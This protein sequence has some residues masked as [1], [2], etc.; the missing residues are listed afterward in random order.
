MAAKRLLDKEEIRRQTDL[1]EVVAAHVQLKASGR[2]LRGL[3]P[4]HP[5]KTGS[6]YVDPDKGLWHCFGCKAGGDVFRFVELISGL[7]FVEAAQWLAR[8][9]GGEYR[10]SQKVERS[11]TARLAALNA[12]AAAFYRR[13][14]FSDEGNFART[15][16]EKRG[17]D[18]EAAVTF[19]LGYAPNDWENLAPFLLDKGF[20]EGELL[21]SGLCL[22]RPRG[23]GL[24]D[25]FRH[26]LI[27]PIADM[28]ERVVAFGGRAL[29]PEDE[30]KYLNSP[31][32]PLF[33]KSRT[34]YGL[35]W[36]ARAMAAKSRTLVVEGYFDLIRC[37]LADFKETVATLGTALT[38]FHLEAL[39]RR[40]E[41]I[42]LAFDSDSAG[43]QAALRSREIVAAA[44]VTVLVLRLP[45]GDDP[46]TFLQSQGGEAL[47]KALANA[48]P[49]LE[50]ALE[51][52]LEKYA[53]KPER[54]RL[55]VLRE[56]GDLLSELSNEAERNFYL[57]W[58]AEKYCGPK[59]ENLGKV[60]QILLNQIR[61]RRAPGRGASGTKAP[62][63]TTLEA[64][65]RQVSGLSPGA[66]L[67]RQ[68]LSGLL[69]QPEVWLQEPEGLALELFSDP[70]HRQIVAVML[71]VAAKGETPEA[72]GLSGRL[73]DNELKTLLAE[74]ALAGS[75]WLDLAEIR[76]LV[77]RL[78]SLRNEEKRRE[79]T[80]LL[81]KEKA[82]PARQKLQAEIHALARERS[83]KVGRRVVGE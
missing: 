32:T 53:G 47:E 7:S 74:L 9:L 18:R 34:L 16:L 38:A 31:E 27:F 2:K 62:D 40:T 54:E 70:G 52:I 67:E 73:E 41:K 29:R 44:G 22:K 81:E 36:A 12:E 65:S 61:G 3:C 58:L 5:E 20:K 50:I 69:S 55:P 72:A 37:H 17:F 26:R 23:T 42:Y 56:G 1:A 19:G 76:K 45:A 24:Y 63:S 51:Q 30:P 48:K 66:K 14:L 35:P 15:Y 59:G 82:E 80:L 77:E 8:R 13:L 46:D 75:P 43:L 33:Q 68:L 25:R 11:E 71:A 79:L 6:F 64:L 83:R 10:L 39:R 49:L 78:H 28:Q 4:F 60:E 21:Q 57:A